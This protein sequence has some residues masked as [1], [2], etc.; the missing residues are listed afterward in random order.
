GPEGDR[1][2][3]SDPAGEFHAAP[4]GR[5]MLVEPPDELLVAGRGVLHRCGPSLLATAIDHR[6]RDGVFVDVHAD[7]Q[8]HRLA[9]STTLVGR[10][11]R[12]SRTNALGQTTLLSSDDRRSRIAGGR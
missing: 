9:S 4:D 6:H 2:P 11:D 3:A 1:E 12:W 5:G 8:F 10:C 7:D